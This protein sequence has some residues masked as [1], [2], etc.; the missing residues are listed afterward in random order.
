MFLIIYKLDSLLNM[1]KVFLL[2]SIWEGDGQ[3]VMGLCSSAVAE[4]N[5]LEEL[6]KGLSLLVEAMPLAAKGPSRS[7]TCYY[8]F[9]D[10]I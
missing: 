9:N 2:S 1:L 4:E 7:S 5:R 6:T 8:N 10:I 3:E